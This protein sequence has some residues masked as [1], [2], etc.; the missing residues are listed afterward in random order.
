MAQ[1][2]GKE[3]NAREVRHSAWVVRRTP[4]RDS[5]LIVEFFTEEDGLLAAFA[6]GARKSKKQSGPALLTLARLDILVG[7]GRGELWHLREVTPKQVL[8]SVTQDYTSLAAAGAALRLV[9]A[10]AREG[11]AE[12]GLFDC[13]CQYLSALDA[14]AK[15]KVLAAQNAS[16]AQAAPACVKGEP[17]LD[18]A[19]PQVEASTASVES[20]ALDLA[21][22]GVDNANTLQENARE[23][24]ERTRSTRPAALG[25]ALPNPR[26]HACEMPHERIALDGLTV[27]VGALNTAF[28]AR[29]LGHLGL[30]PELGRC[31]SC[32]RAPRAEQ[33]VTFE[34]ALEALRCRDCGGGRLELGPLERRSLRYHLERGG[35]LA[36]P[37]ALQP[38]A[39]AAHELVTTALARHGIGA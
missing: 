27:A 32:G 20:A 6:P 39:S 17:A 21:V 22:R 36:E 15:S 23:R 38:L 31:G 34:P 9:R 1:H 11:L 18:A 30:A 25:D 2:N 8:G 16:A 7:R 12:P 26:G 4:Y 24:A 28:R 29:L 19:D 10:A 35:P 37:G 14:L 5:D 13:L 33:R 3:R